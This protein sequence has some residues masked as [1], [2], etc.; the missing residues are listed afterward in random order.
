MGA[1]LFISVLVLQLD[2]HKGVFVP[3]SSSL[4]CSPKEFRWQCWVSGEDPAGSGA[5]PGP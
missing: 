4:E 3:M 1:I 2:L 5:V